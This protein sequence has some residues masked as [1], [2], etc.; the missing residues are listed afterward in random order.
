MDS[1]KTAIVTGAAQG[2]GRGIAL[3]L[4]TDGFNVLITDINAD[5]LV[6]VQDEL[7]SKDLRVAAISGDISDKSFVQK[8]VDEA[9]SHFGGVH[10]VRAY[11]VSF[12]SFS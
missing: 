2:I 6:A 7:S 10:V 9:V 5:K 12:L 8:V 1:T 3:R 4:A 11:S